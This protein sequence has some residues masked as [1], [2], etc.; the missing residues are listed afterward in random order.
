MVITSKCCGLVCLFVDVA[1][2]PLAPSVVSWSGQAALGVPLAAS[3]PP[4]VP[5][6]LPARACVAKCL[7]TLGRP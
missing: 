3:G 4:D 5:D 6:M 7:L 1:V 2:L